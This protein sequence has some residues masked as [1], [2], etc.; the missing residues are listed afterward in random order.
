M[1]IAMTTVQPQDNIIFNYTH[2]YG[3]GFAWGVRNAPARNTV[4]SST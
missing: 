3:V 1:D 4:A 2:D